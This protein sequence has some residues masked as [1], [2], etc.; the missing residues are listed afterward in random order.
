MDHECEIGIEESNGYFTITTLRIL[1]TEVKSLDSPPFII[2]RK[3]PPSARTTFG[4]L[5]ERYHLSK[6]TSRA[7]W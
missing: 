6:V 3:T 1:A 4:L 2:V 5:A 7:A